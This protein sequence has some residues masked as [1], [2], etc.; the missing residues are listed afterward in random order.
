VGHSGKMQNRKEAL[1]V[2]KKYDYVSKSQ[3][4]LADKEGNSILINPK[5]IT[6]KKGDFQ[7]NSNC[8]MINGKLSCRRPEIANEMLSGSKENNVEFLKKILDKT[9]Q[10]GEL[11]TLYST[12]CDLKKGII[13]VYLFHD[14]HMVYT[15]NLKS[16]LKKDTE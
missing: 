7:V 3:V 4:L 2:L 10:E 15:I 9:H 12:V 6:E 14:Y 1:F 13:Y 8:N 5:G 16:E 11:N